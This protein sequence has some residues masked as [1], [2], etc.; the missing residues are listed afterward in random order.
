M[1]NREEITK[2][3]KKYE[4]SADDVYVH[5]TEGFKI[6]KR[7]GYK[8]IQS[9]RNITITF[10][11]VQ[12]SADFAVVSALGMMAHKPEN[13]RQTFGEASPANSLFPYPVAVAQKRAE[14]RLILEMANLYQEGW[15]GEDEID[16][17]VK[18]NIKKKKM[19]K[20]GEKSIDS[21]LSKMGLDEK[22]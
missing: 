19:T 6:I 2:I 9:M 16:F 7:R 8:K 4:L 17:E 22:K 5:D 14:A 20:K 3:I 21:A 13:T 10:E 18:S 15:I 11:C 12:A 1:T